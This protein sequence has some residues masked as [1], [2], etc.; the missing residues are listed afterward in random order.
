MTVLQINYA[1]Y[2]NSSALRNKHVG[3]TFRDLKANARRAALWRWI[4]AR[5]FFRCD[6]VVHVKGAIDA[7][8]IWLDLVAKL[9][10]SRFIAIEHGEGPAPLPTMPDAARKPI[11][12]LRAQRYWLAK[13]CSRIRFWTRSVFPDTTICVSDAARTRRVVHY[14][15]PPSRTIVVRNGVDSVRFSP[16]EESR[17]TVRS[18]WGIDRRTIAIGTMSR[19]APEKGLD[20]LLRAF[21]IL[22]RRAYQVAFKLVIVG[23]GPMKAD[24]ESLATRL[25]VREDVR[26]AGFSDRPWEHLRG[27]DLFALPSR[28]ESLPLALLEA[29]ATGVVP[30]AFDVGGVREIITNVGI[31]WVIPQGDTTLFAEA[32][33]AVSS[34]AIESRRRIG[35]AAREHVRAHFT[36]ASMLDALCERIVG[37]S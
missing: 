14:W 23:E 35:V 21:A 6:V 24:L 1:R 15:F 30:V 2:N 16:N 31:G 7:G 13:M 27:L 22:R 4:A 33:H 36:E 26:F 3:F 5:R 11:F 9:W 29:M 8:S 32:L 28:S 34:L 18:N 25:G 10:S 20:T 17:L 12:P 37:H 19:L